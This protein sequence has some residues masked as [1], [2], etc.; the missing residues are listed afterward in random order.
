MLNEPATDFTD[1]TRHRSSMPSAPPELVYSNQTSTAAR[2]DEVIARPHEARYRLIVMWAEAAL[3]HANCQET[4]DP[5]GV[6]ATV[7]G[8]DGVWA[9]GEDLR[10]VR[11]ELLEVLIAWASL[12]IEQ[13]DDDIPSI[14][15]ISLYRTH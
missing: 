6:V 4:A 2:S 3:R 11:K 8:L 1:A 7:A 15:G 9:Y 5:P 10:E 14:D 13:G 12:K